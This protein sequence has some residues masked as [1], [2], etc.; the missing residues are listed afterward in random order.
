MERYAQ[1]NSK[2]LVVY[3]TYV[4]DV[5]SF[6]EHHPGGASLISNL[7]SKDITKDMAGHFPLSYQL[8]DSM[9]IGSLKK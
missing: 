5:T 8:A 3:D 4:L 9:A 1:D 6:V 2:L 7:S